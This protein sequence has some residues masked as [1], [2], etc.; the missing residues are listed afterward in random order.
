MEMRRNDRN[1]M[2]RLYYDQL[3]I[4]RRPVF[5]Q[6]INKRKFRD[7]F[8]FRVHIRSWH[9]CTLMYTMPANI[10]TN[11]NTV[12]HKIHVIVSSAAYR[13][14]I[15]NH[16]FNSKMK[17]RIHEQLFGANIL[18]DFTLYPSLPLCMVDSPV[19]Q[20]RQPIAPAIPENAIM[21][22]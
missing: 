11:D 19:L 1:A 5:G 12:K 15:N 6:V 13:K 21:R 4:S 18:F 3:N 17:W 16:S 9:F 2:D 20:S 8:I 22:E 10:W 7:D 14:T